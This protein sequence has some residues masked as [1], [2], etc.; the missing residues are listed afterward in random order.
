MPIVVLDACCLIN[1]C[2][3]GDLP[4]ILAALGAELHVSARV[5]AESYFKL[6]RD[7]EGR[8]V[9]VSIDL[10]L[11]SGLLK[12]CDVREGEE[13]GLFV[14]LAAD[15]GDGEATCMAIAKVR[16]WTVATDDRKA[17]RIAEGLGIPMSSTPE[18]MESWAS[19]SG[20]SRAEL[21]SALGNIQ[22]FAR[23]ALRRGSKWDRWWAERLVEE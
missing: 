16:G 17:T 3:A 5:L 23:F 10:A 12:S 8:L 13:T 2:A 4:A 22:T 6:E 20:A 9:P 14:R 19:R 18:L 11:G 1:L 7:E 21:A 15:L